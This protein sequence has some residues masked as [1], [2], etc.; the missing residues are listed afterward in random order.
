MRVT[1]LVRQLQPDLVHANSLSMSRLSGPVCHSLGIP[2]LGHLRDMMRLSPT[3]VR[4]VSQHSRLLAVSAATRD[5]Y[6]NLGFAADQVHVVYNG[7]DLQRF[8]PTAP[9]GFLHRELK[10]PVSTP[11]IGSIGQIGIRKGM[12]RLLAA[13]ADLPSSAAHLILIGERHSQKTEAIEFEAE[14]HRFATFHLPG[15]THFLGRREDIEELL[16]ELTILAH[17][18]R[19]EPLGR[20]LLEAA[21]CGCCIVATDVGGTQEIF[22]P[23][24]GSAALISGQDQSAATKTLEDLLAN[25]KRRQQM[26]GLARKRASDAFDL[27]RACRSLM[28]HY[29]ALL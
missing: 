11:L 24:S 8:R 28:Q 27:H 2:S 6:T 15:R 16:S 4:D 1:E 22:P 14:L 3:A 21:A 26:K 13:V 18:A 9:A 17:F 7:V 29:L 23:D 12:D 20:V 10:L 25:A 5:W 19:Q